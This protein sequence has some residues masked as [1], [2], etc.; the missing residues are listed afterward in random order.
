MFLMAAPKHFIDPFAT[1]DTPFDSSGAGERIP[2]NGDSHVELD[3]TR[4]FNSAP[5]H[6]MILHVC[7]YVCICHS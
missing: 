2:S 5:N 1:P 3:D 7:V 4:H 6:I